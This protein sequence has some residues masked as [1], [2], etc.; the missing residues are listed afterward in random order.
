MT[1]NFIEW[2]GWYGMAAI[3]LSYALVSFSLL[4]ATSIWYQLLN[5]TG[6]LG[7]VVISYRKR[8]YQPAVLNVIWVLIALAAIANILF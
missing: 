7:I 5:V 8:A 4:E 2:F 3:V 1:Q 6:A